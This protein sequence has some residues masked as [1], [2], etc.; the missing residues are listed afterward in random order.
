LAADLRPYRPNVGIALFDGQGRVLIAR[1]IGDDGPE[2]VLPGGEWQ[3][4][5]GGID[6]SENPEAAARRELREETGVTSLEVLGR[7]EEWLTYEFPPYGGPPHKLAAFRGQRQ[8][9][10]AMHLLGDETEIDVTGA[11]PDGDP[12]FSEWR[13]ERLE[14]VPRLVVPFK[15]AVYA[16]VAAA[17]ARFAEGL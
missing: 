14:A 11:P 3:M 8:L 15:A 7:M 2:I 4:P 5:Q 6:G 10:F 9:W 17:F 1:R 12:E 13:W 16:R